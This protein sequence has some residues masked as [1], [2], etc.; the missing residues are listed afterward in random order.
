MPPAR[1]RAILLRVLKFVVVNKKCLVGFSNRNIISPS[2]MLL[3]S[4]SYFTVHYSRSN[5]PKSYINQRSQKPQQRIISDRDDYSFEKTSASTHSR[6]QNTTM[7]MEASSID[8]V[9]PTT[10]TEGEFHLTQSPPSSPT[11][12]WTAPFSSIAPPLTSVADGC[13]PTCGIQLYKIK[14]RL[15]SR[16]PIAKP[17]TVDGHV[18]RGNCIACAGAGAGADA[19]S[20]NSRPESPIDTTSN[21]SLAS[22]L[23][24]GVTV[25]IGDYN[26]YGQRH[27]PGE[28][29]WNNGDRFAGNFFNGH[30][31]GHGTLFF[32]DGMSLRRLAP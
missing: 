27:G 26:I 2:K 14:K 21:P 5:Q 3:I 32:G 31:D 30:R 13:C 8:Y 17:L 6:C 12:C 29:T 16:K 23:E 25:Y 28:L 18:D 9:T 15:L 11:S 22:S 19:H 7:M 24:M 10:L 1:R 4:R 20:S